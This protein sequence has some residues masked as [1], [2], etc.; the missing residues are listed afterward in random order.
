MS[1]YPGSQSETIPFPETISPGASHKEFLH[2]G[3][4][5]L[6]VTLVSCVSTAATLVPQPILLVRTVPV[7]LSLPHACPA[8]CRSSPVTSAEPY[9]GPEGY[10]PLPPKK[11]LLTDSIPQVLLRLVPCFVFALIVSFVL[12]QGPLP[13]TYQFGTPIPPWPSEKKAVGRQGQIPLFY[14]NHISL[15]PHPINYTEIAQFCAT[16]RHLNIL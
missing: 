4:S 16:M 11:W 14:M 7:C 8:P 10:Q 1:W 5:E 15:A 3:L 6:L 2:L 13:D 9:P 12:P